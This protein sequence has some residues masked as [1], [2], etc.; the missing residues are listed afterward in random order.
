[1][2]LRY[3]I[4]YIALPLIAF[5]L[6]LA[7]CSDD[8]AS[9]GNSS[10]NGKTKYDWF[11]VN[12]NAYSH[13]MKIEVNGKPFMAFTD[14]SGFDSKPTPLVEG[15]NRI[16]IT[17]Q[18]KKN[19]Q[20]SN[21]SVRILL[22]PTMIVGAA[23][24]PG[25]ELEPIE[26]YTEIELTIKIESQKPEAFSYILSE[27][28]SSDKQTMLYQLQVDKDAFMRRPLREQVKV[29]NE[30]GR[31]F[32]ET[33]YEEDKILNATYYKPDGSIGA[34]VINSNGTYREWYGDG[35]LFLEA[36]IE[37]GKYTGVVKEYAEDGTIAREI[38]AEQWLQE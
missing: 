6:L 2:P 18:P 24:L 8:A 1:M 26:N 35:S 27:W 3:P 17:C 37:A 9:T 23:P 4:L 10:V 36:T 13:E 22:S 7:G 20:F 11:F 30:D 19:R 5:T 29:W 14:G 16:T 25:I 21:T 33:Q 38:S 31:P 12:Y 28:S 32:R 15:E 34:T